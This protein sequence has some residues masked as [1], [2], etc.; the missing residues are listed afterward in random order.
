[1]LDKPAENWELE[2]AADTE[3]PAHLG[4]S[5]SAANERTSAANGDVECALRQLAKVREYLDA[6]LQESDPEQAMLGIANAMLIKLAVRIQAAIDG[7]LDSAATD[8]ACLESAALG[9]DQLLRVIGMS[10]GLV[11]LKFAM[12]EAKEALRRLRQGH[13]AAHD[14]LLLGEEPEK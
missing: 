1:M 4:N 10:R 8:A 2:T 5:S 12:S 14:S 6:A 9:I 11:H 3:V 13:R 7:V